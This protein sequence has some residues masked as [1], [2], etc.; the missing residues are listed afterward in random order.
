[1]VVLGK[2]GI[3]LASRLA[4]SEVLDVVGADLAIHNLEEHTL[5]ITLS[6]HDLEQ[7]LWIEL[8]V[9]GVSGF[10]ANQI[11]EVF[12]ESTY[13]SNACI[14]VNNLLWGQVVHADIP[15]VAEVALSDLSNNVFL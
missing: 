10:G 2:E 6:F 11:L 12:F 7:L 15:I 9:A 4:A 8:H 3:I 5:V 1:L 14:Q 13:D